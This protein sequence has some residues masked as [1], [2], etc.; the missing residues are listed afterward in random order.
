MASESQTAG[1]ER[2]APLFYVSPGQ[3][4]YDVPPGTTLGTATV[5]ITAGDNTSISTP[6]QIVRVAPGIFELNSWWRPTSC[7]SKLETC[8]RRK[9]C[10]RW[11]PLRSNWWR[12]RCTAVSRETRKSE[13]ASA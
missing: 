6:L 9:P 3:A 8:K 2:L 1:T 5:T 13:I 10:T 7:A 11:I 12:C 4:N